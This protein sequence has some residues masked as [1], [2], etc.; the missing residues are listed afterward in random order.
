MSSFPGCKSWRQILKS[1]WPRLFR[2]TMETPQ[3]QCIDEIDVPV[4]CRL[5]KF[6]GY[7]SWR[8]QP[9]SNSVLENSE[10]PKTQMIQSARTYESSVTA[11]VCQMT[12]AEIGEV[13]E[14]GASIPAESASPV[15]VT[16]PVLE[17]SPIVAGSVQPAHVAEDM[18]HEPR[19]LPATTMAVAHRLVDEK[20]AD[21]MVS[22]IRDLKSDLVHIR[23]LLGVLVR[24]ERS[25][26][27]KAEIAA[28]RLNRMERER[29]QESEAEC[30]ATLEEALDRSLKGREGDRGQMVCR[31][32]VRLW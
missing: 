21:D 7:M 17:N 10:T 23:E 14:I 26:E 11:P 16:A 22:E 15:L 4:W 12:Q 9:T 25:A 30:E 2:K 20:P 19:P 28:R 32:R 27:T 18:A 8:R 13:I 29:D 3:S 24:K 5:C 6:Q 31:Q 1:P